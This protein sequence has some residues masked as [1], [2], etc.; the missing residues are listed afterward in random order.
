MSKQSRRFGERD[1]ISLPAKDEEA[2]AIVLSLGAPRDLV[3]ATDLPLET[4]NLG[5]VRH[6]YVMGSVG[7]F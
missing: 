6:V 4:P 3:A 5:E 1:R 2:P 7:V